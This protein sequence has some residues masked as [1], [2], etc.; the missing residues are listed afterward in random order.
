M[1]RFEVRHI[2]T[3]HA[4]S[5]IAVAAF[6]R[7][8]VTWDIMTGDHICNLETCLDFGGDRLAISEDGRLLA[9][10]SFRMK[11]VVAYSATDGSEIWKRDN[12]GAIQRLAFDPLT[13]DLLVGA[14][15]RPTYRLRSLSGETVKEY[16][17]VRALTPSPYQL[18]LES[19]ETR[20]RIRVHFAG[21]PT[22][23]MSIDMESLA[24]LSTAFTPDHILVSESAGAVRCFDL[25]DGKLCWR[26]DPPQGFHALRIAYCESSDY[27]ACLLWHYETGREKQIVMLDARTG[28]VRQSADLEGTP[29]VAEFALKGCALITSG[30]MVYTVKGR[31]EIIASKC[32]SF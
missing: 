7:L 1:P 11:H 13:G 4:G 19:H 14:E 26:H 30:G 10:A 15:G 27:V 16:R 17:G 9:A 18:G 5:R 25:H 8:V 12:L 24:V 32:F 2:A 29:V 22:A 6:E 21:Q 3:S 23:D 28:R 31:S 20:K